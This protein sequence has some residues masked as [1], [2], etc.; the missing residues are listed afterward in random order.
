MPHIF[1]PGTEYPAVT[2]ARACEPLT[3]VL[4]PN[5]GLLEEQQTRFNC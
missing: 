4:A 2:F 5:S 3:W 1:S